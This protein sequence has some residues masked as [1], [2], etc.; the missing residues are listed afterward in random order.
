MKNHVK[1]PTCVQGQRWEHPYAVRN[2]EQGRRHRLCKG[3]G[4]T[5]V[6]AEMMRPDYEET[7]MPIIKK[8]S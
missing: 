7:F 6:W 1:G 4:D 8:S 2:T 3:D 5:H